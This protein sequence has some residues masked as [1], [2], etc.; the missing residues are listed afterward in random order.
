MEKVC[1]ITTGATAPF[2]ELVQ[3]VLKPESLQLLADNGFTKLIFQCG[4]TFKSFENL[5]PTDHKGLDI[6][7]FDFKADGLNREMRM[8]QAHEGIANNGLVICHAGAGTI[9]DGM[10]LGLSLIVV[11][12]D[13]LLDNHQL[14]LAEEL[15]LQG[16]ATKSTTSDLPNAIQ[17]A[18]QRGQRAWAGHN[19]SFAQEIDKVVGYEDD[20]RARLD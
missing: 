7:V 5:M 10:R 17:I 14:E 15:E 3:A 11:P 20:V 4:Q 16:Y 19:A 1:L 13:S 2:P 12:N 9:L 6:E 8:C 18:C